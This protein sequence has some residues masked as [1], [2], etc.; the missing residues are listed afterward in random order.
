[1]NKELKQEILDALEFTSSM[2]RSMIRNSLDQ[3][4]FLKVQI[5]LASNEQLINKINALSDGE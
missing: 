4:T 3:A 5:Q 1:M 2:L